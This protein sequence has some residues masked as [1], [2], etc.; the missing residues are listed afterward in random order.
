LD[1]AA[2][3]RDQ[4]RTTLA[5]ST[6]ASG[7]IR[8]FNVLRSSQMYDFPQNMRALSLIAIMRLLR[9]VYIRQVLDHAEYDKGNWKE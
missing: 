1:E 2:T 4:R 8:E 5:Q 3:R 6:T 9:K 7:R